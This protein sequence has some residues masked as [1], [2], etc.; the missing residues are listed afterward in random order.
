MGSAR[1][2]QHTDKKENKADE[3]ETSGAEA[4]ADTSSK[5]RTDAVKPRELDDSAAGYVFDENDSK[6]ASPRGRA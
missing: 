6:P 5:L 2:F 4:S 1:P 3:V